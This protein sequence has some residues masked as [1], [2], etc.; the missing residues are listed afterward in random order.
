MYK[1]HRE[2]LSRIERNRR[3][4]VTTTRSVGGK[5]EPTSDGRR[6][7]ADGRREPWKVGWM[8]PLPDVEREIGKR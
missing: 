3:E 4:R 2:I 7:K 6:R 8:D 5:S 1:R